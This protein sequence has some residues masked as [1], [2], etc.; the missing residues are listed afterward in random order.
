MGLVLIHYISKTNGDKWDLCLGMHRQMRDG[1]GR[2]VLARPTASTCLGDAV[3][4][5]NLVVLGRMCVCLCACVCARVCVY[6]FSNPST[7][8][9]QQKALQSSS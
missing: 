4:R 1:I 8:L 5:K 2:V 6:L 3:L 9:F 7:C